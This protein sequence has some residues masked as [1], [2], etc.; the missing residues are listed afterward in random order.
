M[1]TRPRIALVTGGANGIGRATAEV[2]AARG[3]HVWIGDLDVAAG[4]RW[5]AEQ[6]AAGGRVSFVELDVADEDSIRRVASTMEADV[7]SLD[8]LVNCAG[9]ALDNVDDTLSAPSQLPLARFRETTTVNVVGAMA[10]VQTFL[11][12]SP[13]GGRGTRRDR[14]ERP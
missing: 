14:F 7:P 12:L 6:E 8:A 11:P 9:V 2:L 3:F 10:V 1:S 5:A 13:E 4:K